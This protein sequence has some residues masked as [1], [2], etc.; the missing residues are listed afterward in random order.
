MF[1]YVLNQVV[2]LVDYHIQALLIVASNIEY[3]LIDLLLEVAACQ[4]SKF[5]ENGGGGDLFQA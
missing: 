4:T 1:T 5:F 2:E 3:A